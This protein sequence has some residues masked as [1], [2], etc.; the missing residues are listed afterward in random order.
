MIFIFAADKPPISDLPYFL[1]F[2]S[3]KIWAPIHNDLPLGPLANRT[4]SSPSL[5][6]NLMGPKLYVNTNK[7]LSI[8]P[9]MFSK[10]IHQGFIS[11]YF[12]C[13]RRYLTYILF[14]QVVV[15]KKPVTGMRLFLE[16]MKCNR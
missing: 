4:T 7:V 1:D 8:S 15:G 9:Q 5:T 2:Q 6:F 3:H 12:L 10:S 13:L 11:P 16:G 14:Y